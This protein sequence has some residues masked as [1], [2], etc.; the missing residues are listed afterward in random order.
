MDSYNDGPNEHK[1]PMHSPWNTH[2]IATSDPKIPLE[3]LKD[4]DG[5]FSS[6]P[7]SMS[8]YLTSDGYLNTAHAP[9]GGRWK[10]MKKILSTEI[11]S[12]ARHKW[13]LNK[14]DEEHDNIIRNAILIARK[15]Q[16]PLVD[17]RI[18]QWKDGVRTKQDDLLDVFINLKR[19]SLTTDEIKA[20][21]LDLMLAS[22]D[23]VWNNIE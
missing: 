8:G 3:F 19:S 12:V 13:L 1:H 10:K 4:T 23:N 18:Q 16:D 21:I 2:V 5:M 17:E 9:M 20:H 7:D 6:R 15:Y 11:L 22:L 14:R